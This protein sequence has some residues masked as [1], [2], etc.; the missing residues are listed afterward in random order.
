VV[1]AQ[2]ADVVSRATA[3]DEAGEERPAV[4][5]ARETNEWMVS[6]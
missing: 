4:A 2:R 1:D 5:V 6:P 3:L